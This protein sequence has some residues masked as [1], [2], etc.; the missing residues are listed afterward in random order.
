MN[1]IAWHAA[2][3]ALGS[4]LLDVPPVDEIRLTDHQFGFELRGTEGSASVPDL[5]IWRLLGPAAEYEASSVF[6]YC[7]DNEEAS[8]R[9][10]AQRFLDKSYLKGSVDD[11]VTYGRVFARK[12]VS[13]YQ[14]TLSHL[15]G[16]LERAGSIR[17]SSLEHMRLVRGIPRGQQIGVRNKSEF[18]FIP[19]QEGK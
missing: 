11:V 10:I 7:D 19:S 1:P 13:D 5:F 4:M 14:I 12:L 16:D 15:V 8:V 3:H 9:D 6:A 18:G 17:G 2:G